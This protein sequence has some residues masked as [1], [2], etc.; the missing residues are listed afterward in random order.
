MSMAT[1][2]DTSGCDSN[3][4]YSSRGHSQHHYG[5]NQ[6]HL[7][8]HGVGRHHIISSSNFLTES[9]RA[10]RALDA[11]SRISHA[12][13]DSEDNDKLI[14]VDEF[15]ES[16]CED[17]RSCTTLSPTPSDH[18]VNSSSSRQYNSAGGRSSGGNGCGKLRK[19]SGIASKVMDEQEL[20]S[21]RL[22]INS[23]ERKR[24]HDL[25]SA[26]DGLREVMP[27]AH[28]PSVRKLSKIATLLLAK[29]YILMLNS[30]LEEMKKLVSD[31]YHNHGQPRPAVPAPP[32]SLPPA[33]QPSPAVAPSVVPVSSSSI[34]AG[35]STSPSDSTPR[36]NSPRPQS[37]RCKSQEGNLTPPRPLHQSSMP[38]SQLAGNPIPHHHHLGAPIFPLPIPALRA[39]MPA[40]SHHDISA[41]ASAYSVPKSDLGA[42]LHGIHAFSPHDRMHPFQRWPVPCACVQCLNGT[43]HLSLGLHLSRLSHPLLSSSNT[44]Q[45]K[46]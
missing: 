46:S 6:S 33:P 27:Y 4:Y 30:S 35:T 43:G 1:E 38:H 21:L 13:D 16:D 3:S 34:P 20:Q 5:F 10:F 29:N 15:D 14:S 11:E 18:T 39:A 26:L 8:Q 45:R 28:G 31:I 17:V 24:M 19:K 36:S 32:P 22:K 41:L 23:R 25:N 37:P 12:S 2:A 44:V 42:P 9:E 40:L 7:Q